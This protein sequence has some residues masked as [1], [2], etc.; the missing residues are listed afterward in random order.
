MNY[1]SLFDSSG[2]RVTSVPCD[3][4]LTDEK[5]AALETEGYVEIDADEWNYYVGNKGNGANGTGYI[6]GTDGKPVS[7]PKVTITEDEVKKKQLEALDAEYES[8][9]KAL[10]SQY[11]DAAMGG[12]SDTMATIKT[13]ITKLNEKYDADYKSIKG[14]A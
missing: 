4:D 5:K 9:K 13:E 14:E 2:V 3:N 11:L 10:A 8:D 12:D 1:M 7:A 6:R